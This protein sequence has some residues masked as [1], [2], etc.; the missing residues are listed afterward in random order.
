MVSPELINRLPGKLS[1]FSELDVSLNEQVPVLNLSGG[2]G[3]ANGSRKKNE[4]D[5]SPKVSATNLTFETSACAPLDL[6][7]ITTPVPVGMYPKNLPC[8]SSP[9]ELISTFNTVDDA[10]YTEPNDT[11]VLYGFAL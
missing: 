10:E 2:G 7:K 5:M 9:R 3:D 1:A 4:P 8:A 6:P 11:D